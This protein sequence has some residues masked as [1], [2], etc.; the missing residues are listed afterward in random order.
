M[1]LTQVK[2]EGIAADAV[3]ATKIVDDA[4]GS[5]HIEQLDADLSFADSAKARWGAGNDLSIY[6][7]GSTSLLEGNDVRIRNAAGDE[8]LAVFTNGGSVDL[9]Y[10]NIK[11]LQTDG[12]GIFVYGPEGGA[13]NVYLYADEGDDDADK[14]SLSSGTDGTFTINNRASG[15]FE[16][17]I[18]CNGDGNVELYHDN[19]K[20]FE[21]TAAGVTVTGT[22]TDS[23]GDV[24]KSVKNEQANAY[25]LVAADSGKVVGAQNTITIPASVF[26]DGDMITIV[27][28]TSGNITLTQG[29]GLT[30][31]NSADAST[32]NKT[33]AARGM[34]T[35]WFPAGTTAYMSGTGI[36]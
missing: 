5:E 13:S 34:A 9:Y 6:S 4:V 15:S 1:A 28:Y 14:W 22:V 26:G 18:E 36:S 7:N 25:T 32:G 21:T 24:R 12:N 19:S 10:N 17:N 16:K 30:L 23:K 33:L 2:T 8:T 29:S 20:K 11:S 3:T 27:N 31:Y 35:V